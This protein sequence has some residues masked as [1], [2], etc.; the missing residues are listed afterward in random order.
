MRG[1]YFET[2]RPFIDEHGLEVSAMNGPPTA[3]WENFFVAEVGAAAALT[4]LLFVAVSINLARILAVA[5]LPDRAGETLVVF[6]GALAVATFGLIPDQ[7]HV[8]LGCEV[9]ATGLLVWGVTVRTQWRS[10]RYV[11]ARQWLARR[12]VGTQLATLPFVV[13]GA[14][15]V[16]GSRSG[17]YWVVA[18]VLASF[19][20]GMQNAWVLLVEILR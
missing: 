13:G 10:Y 11:D 19:A 7:G 12:V 2:V 14:L 1:K 8:A 5:H 3:G 20:S 6:G 17:L 16:G 18:G 9:G 4:G 15:L